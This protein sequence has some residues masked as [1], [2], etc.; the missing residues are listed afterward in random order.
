MKN[1][2]MKWKI[3][4][5]MVCILTL[6]VII[7]TIFY[8]LRLSRYTNILFN[9][10]I[11]VA[12]NGLKAF[13]S[14]C[15]YS[16]RVAA[17]YATENADIIEAVHM[18]NTSEIIQLLTNSLDLYHVDFFVVTDENG[19]VIARTFTDDQGDSIK[20]QTNIQEA[21]QGK[22]FTCI[23]E[24]TYA[25]VSVSTGAPVYKKGKLI[26]VLSAGIRF[27][28]N[29]TL[30]LLKEHYNADFSVIYRGTRIATTIFK[31]D[32][33]ITGTPLD[34][35]MMER[36]QENQE[37]YFGNADVLN[38]NYSAFYMPL[39]NNRGEVFALIFAGYS[40]AKLIVEKNAILKSV[41]LIGLSGLIVSIIILL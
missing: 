27:D 37:E 7:M 5:P 16:T 39:L 13:I 23:E 28:R 25:K 15:E 35:V 9:D 30:D 6:L 10:N 12:A 11:T 31:E 4:L 34:P 40:N 41:A 33:R 22:V 1:I 29:E 2:R 26:G 14:E 17:V 32:N 20:D 38:E 3:I 19:V 18:Q 8:S 21:L 36:F 24:G